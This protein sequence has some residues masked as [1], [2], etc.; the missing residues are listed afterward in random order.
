M[1]FWNHPVYMRARARST[2][3]T[4]SAP[5]AYE[6]ESR[7]V[8]EKSVIV[9]RRSLSVYREL[10]IYIVDLY[11]KESHI[12]GDSSKDRENADNESWKDE[13]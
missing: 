12:I 9:D 7:R 4:I 10:L 5:G 8:S 6:E 13:K 2:S 3:L 1:I 11:K